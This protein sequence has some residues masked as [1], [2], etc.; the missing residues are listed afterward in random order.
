MWNEDIQKL[1]EHSN[2]IAEIEK[3]QCK[4]DYDINKC[5][6]SERIPMAEDY[7]REKEK[8]LKRNPYEEALNLKINAVLI[9]E[10]LNTFVQALS[11]K[12]VFIV[13]LFVIGLFYISIFVKDVSSKSNN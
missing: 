13:F 4:R 1:K 3:E 11:I 8:C 2:M 12:S 9:G 7:C 10:T 5:D 6:P